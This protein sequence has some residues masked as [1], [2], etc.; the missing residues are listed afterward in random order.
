MIDGLVSQ[1]GD[2]VEK[3][4]KRDEGGTGRYPPASIHVG[5]SDTEPLT[6]N[7]GEELTVHTGHRLGNMEHEEKTRR[8]IDGFIFSFYRHY[9]IYIY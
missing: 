3:L 4:W 7:R 2:E 6:V 5:H 9:L 1:L 8:C